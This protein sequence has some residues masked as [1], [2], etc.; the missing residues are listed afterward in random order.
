[1]S[2]SGKHPVK[3]SALLLA[4]AFGL[5]ACGGGD[6]A[7][8]G[9]NEA[10]PTAQ[11]GELA[12]K[13]EIVINNGAEPESLDPHKV[14][15]VPESGILR[16][17][18]V[19]LTTTDADGNTIPGMAE[20]WESA[21]NKT[22]TFHLRDAKWSNGDPVTAEDFAYSLR[23][24]TDPA[25][26][27][28]YASY[29]ADAKVANAQAIIDGKAKPDTLGVKA[30]DP[31]T[32]EI[33][34]SEP[35]PYFPDMMVHT[36]V[37]PVNPK[38]VQELG[39]KWTAP[40]NF[41]GNGAYN[42]KEWAVN[43]QIVLERNKNY[44]DDAHTTINKATL[45]PISSP[46]TDV[47]RYKAGEVDMSYTDLPSEQFQSLKQE[48]G[49]Q[50]KVAPMLCTYYYE[51]NTTKAPFDNP[52]VR[53]ALALALDRDTLVN[54]VIGRGETVA[55][56]YTP[57]ATQGDKPFEPEWKSW[58]KEQRIAEA[59]K[60]LAEAGYGDG[61]PLNFELLYNTN[62]NHKKAAVAASSLWKEALG[63][64]NITLTNQEWKT[65]L[66]SRRTQKFQMARGGWCADYNEPSSFLNTLKSG[67]SNN[68]AKYT[69]A[70]FD[71]LLDK[72]LHPDTTPEQRADLYQQAEAVLDVD[73][74]QANVYH[75]VSARLVKP[76]VA[77]YSV[78]DPM[79]NWQIK[80]LSV[81]KH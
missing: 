46:P 43:S 78:K 80:N 48:M 75:Y 36:S 61:K 10:K 39:D 70:Q 68:H 47:A 26:A 67:N 38:V 59:K 35:V 29:L 33:T 7:P 79:D 9:G 31:K 51:M 28:P 42:L 32:L 63:F 52:K 60:L 25:T 12:E 62:E 50:L 5:T 65:Y 55:Y 19:G 69:S 16:Q 74:P 45:L 44:Y 71:S 81:L 64:V 41:V 24:V 40:G 15:G 54:K 17:L 77:G 21:D 73:Q 72:T 27:S 37:K 8:A 23:R 53:R 13:Q 6:K 3:T 22:W 30:I 66:D 2:T 58:S 76:Y 57:N 49:D 4:L 1:M 18:L 11:A 34:L 20:K 56:Q 14:S